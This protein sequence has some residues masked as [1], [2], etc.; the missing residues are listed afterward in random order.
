MNYL[1]P[2]FIN[3]QQLRLLYRCSFFPFA[4]CSVS[5]APPSASLFTL[6]SVRP[7]WSMATI[8]FLFTFLLLSVASPS[9]VLHS[10]PVKDIVAAM[11]HPQYLPRNR[12]L[13]LP[14]H[15]FCTPYQS[16]A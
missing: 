7:Y 5:Y 12:T 10:F 11:A 14:F 8:L 15:P 3:F 4:H 2:F 6:L 16:A 1:Q 9:V 13:S